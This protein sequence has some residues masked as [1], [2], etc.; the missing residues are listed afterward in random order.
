MPDRIEPSPRFLADVEEFGDTCWVHGSEY[1][2]PQFERL[3]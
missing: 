2:V 1:A 3:E